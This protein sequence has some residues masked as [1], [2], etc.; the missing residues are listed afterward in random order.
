MIMIVLIIMIMLIIIILM[1]R[2][3]SPGVLGALDLP[4]AHR[5]GAGPADGELCSIISS[6][7]SSSSSSGSSG[8]SGSSSSSS[9]SSSS[10]SNSSTLHTV[11]GQVPQRV[12]ERGSDV[13]LRG[14]GTLG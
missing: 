11:E 12:R 6:G 8:S 14:V 2:V 10:R 13:L 1:I 9:S 7:S 4:P 3:I 5:R